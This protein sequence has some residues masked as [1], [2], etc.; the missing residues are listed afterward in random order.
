V[1]ESDPG[2]VPA[3][4]DTV[5]GDVYAYP[6]NETSTGVTVRCIDQ[7]VV[8]LVVVDGTSAA[9]GMRLALEQFDVYY[10]PQKCFAA[11]PACGRASPSAVE[12]AN[13]CARAVAGCRR[14]TRSAP[15][16]RQ[17]QTYNT[18]ALATLFLVANQIE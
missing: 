6:H 1:L 4:L 9:G 8:T 13:S 11:T 14:S 12:R 5:A 16:T 15:T 18:P 2:A 10:L 3:T 17:D 7:P